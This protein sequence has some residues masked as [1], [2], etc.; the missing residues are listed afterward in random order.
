MNGRAVT[1]AIVLAAPLARADDPP[2]GLFTPEENTLEQVQIHGVGWSSPRG[3]GDLRI[4][5]E[6]L[7]SSPHQQTSEMLSVAP[8]FFVDHEDSE[9]LGNDVHLR[10][11][12]LDHGSGIEMRL[13]SIPEVN[14]PLHILGQGYADVSFIIPESRARDSR[15]SRGTYDPRAKATLTRSSAVRTSISAY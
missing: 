8:G 9:G 13:G 7:D 12:D 10:G 14:V 5:R 6:Q 4:T 3:I 11:F 15:C 2:Q 1:I